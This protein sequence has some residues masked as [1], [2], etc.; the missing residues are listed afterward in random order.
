MT[1]EP[2]KD[3]A[4]PFMDTFLSMMMTGMPQK[5]P[6]ADILYHCCI[7]ARELLVYWDEKRIPDAEIAS[8]KYHLQ[9]SISGLT[10]KRFASSNAL[11]SPVSFSN[12]S[13][14]SWILKQLVV[15]FDNVLFHEATV[16]QVL[17]KLQDVQAVYEIHSGFSELVVLLEG[18][19]RVILRCPGAVWRRIWMERLSCAAQTYHARAAL[20]RLSVGQRLSFLRGYIWDAAS[21]S[22]SSSAMTT[23][24][25]SASLGL[26]SSSS[27]SAR[28][29]SSFSTTVSRTAYLSPE[30]P[31][32]EHPAV[33]SGR[34]LSTIDGVSGPRR[35][36]DGIGKGSAV[37]TSRFPVGVSVFGFAKQE[38]QKFITERTSLGPK[39]LNAVLGTTQGGPTDVQYLSLSLTTYCNTAPAFNNPQYFICPFSA[40]ELFT[41]ELDPLTSVEAFSCRAAASSSVIGSLKISSTI[42]RDAVVEIDPFPNAR[43]RLLGNSLSDL[44]F[45]LAEVSRHEILDVYRPEESNAPSDF[46]EVRP[47]FILPPEVDDTEED[48]NE[49]ESTRQLFSS[50]LNTLTKQ[51]GQEETEKN[52]RRSRMVYIYICSAQ[53]RARLSLEF[54]SQVWAERFSQAMRL[55]ISPN[56][57][58]RPNPLSTDGPSSPLSKRPETFSLYHYPSLNFLRAAQGSLTLKLLPSGPA[59]PDTTFKLLFETATL[60]CPDNEILEEADGPGGGG[61]KARVDRLLVAIAPYT[62]AAQGGAGL[63]MQPKCYCEDAKC[64]LACL[65]ALHRGDA[66]KIWAERMESANS[67]F[68]VSLIRVSVLLHHA[69]TSGLLSLCRYA[70]ANFLEKPLPIEDYLAHLHVKPIRTL[71]IDWLFKLLTGRNVTKKEP[72]GSVKPDDNKGATAEAG[73]E[74]EDEDSEDSDR[75]E[76]EIDDDEEEEE[77]K[78]SMD[79]VALDPDLVYPALLP[80]LVKAIRWTTPTAFN[81]GLTNLM[82]LV[83]RPKVPIVLG[84]RFPDWPTWWLPLIM[85]QRAFR[86][87]GDVEKVRTPRQE[88][89]PGFPVPD[90]TAP[91]SE[92]QQSKS[93]ERKD[94]V[95]DKQK[96][97]IGVLTMAYVLLHLT[98]GVHMTQLIATNE[99]TS[100]GR[101]A[102]V[103]TGYS[104]TELGKAL[105]GGTGTAEDAAKQIPADLEFLVPRILK[106]IQR[107]YGWSLPVVERTQ[108]L[109]YVLLHLIIRHI[110]NPLAKLPLYPCLQALLTTAEDFC[111]YSPLIRDWKCDRCGIKIRTSTDQCPACGGRSRTEPNSAQAASST[112]SSSSGGQSSGATNEEVRASLR[113]ETWAQDFKIIQEVVQALQLFEAKQRSDPE[114]APEV[115]AKNVSDELKDWSATFAA[116]K[117]ILDAEVARQQIARVAAG[118]ITEEAVAKV[119]PTP[120]LVSLAGSLT[121]QNMSIV[122]VPAWRSKKRVTAELAGMETVVSTQIP[123]Q[124]TGRFR[125]ISTTQRRDS[126]KPKMVPLSEALSSNKKGW[127]TAIGGKFMAGLAGSQGG[128]ITTSRFI[129]EDEEKQEHGEWVPL[130]EAAQAMSA[131]AKSGV[132]F[133]TK[134]HISAK[135]KT[136]AAPRSH[137]AEDDDDMAEESKTA[138]P[139]EKKEEPEPIVGMVPLSQASEK[140]GNSRFAD[141]DDDD[142][143]APADTTSSSSQSV[144]L[145]ESLPSSSSADSLKRPSRSLAIEPDNSDKA[146]VT[147]PVRASTSVP[148]PSKVGASPS[149]SRRMWRLG[150]F[151]RKKT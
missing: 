65:A 147:S 126:E 95:Q 116:A 91:T 57:L 10:N 90:A 133:T 99:Q 45:T 61:A 151:S 66:L 134:F 73:E 104:R 43:I 21:L 69:V 125:S 5:H 79:S 149:P 62:D 46:I 52:S 105:R 86:G 44:G 11:S 35:A 36:R 25:S 109:L 3:K 19:N 32:L 60:L 30:S 53:G 59:V 148:L 100:E 106:M 118:E 131:S 112:V 127:G 16:E 48:L 93:V 146:E 64:P 122:R 89:T 85:G 54:F 94:Q 4:L 12:N 123:G 88:D 34:N 18:G 87:P 29:K 101:K 119:D 135:N 50:A 80:A 39:D 6:L 31:V 37:P 14:R 38:K 67:H 82:L 9:S 108:Q 124:V 47:P 40:P 17:F 42:W 83:R 33:P 107:Y 41:E 26:P 111:F 137:F 28:P 70:Q 2:F 97:G 72:R 23:S 1:T 143:A 49:S 140:K 110:Q 8:I 27:F 20:S 130:S 129:D 68:R 71:E 56:F 51:G 138:P 81:L 76:P 13:G 114:A 113:L 75:E 115:N 15:R 84:A 145:E 121:K 58:A 136:S 141:D 78:D 102:S 103:A 7:A 117:G 74:E 63:I 144:P 55:F 24:T 139:E 96:Q 132:K 98:S 92:A 150:K 128:N 120:F 22:L 142:D 77:E